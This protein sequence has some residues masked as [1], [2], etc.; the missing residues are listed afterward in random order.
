MAAMCDPDKCTGCGLCASMCR[1]QAITMVCKRHGHLYPQIYKEKCTNCGLCKQICPANSNIRKVIPQHA[2]AAWSKDYKEYTTST[3]GGASAELAKFFIARGGVVYG[4]TIKEG[5]KAEHIRVENAK[6]L[7]LIK[8]SK[9]VQSNMVNAIPLIREDVRRGKD[10]LFLGT[11]CQVGALRRLI[12]ETNPHL[13]LVDLICHGVPSQK[14]LYNHISKI[15]I[16]NSLTRICFRNGKDLEMSIYSGNKLVYCSDAYNQ[17]Y[18]DSYYAAFVE[19]FSF[20]SSCYSCPYA[21]S[22][23]C[24]DLTIGDFWGLK[25]EEKSIPEHPHGCSLILS[26]TEKGQRLIN[27]ISNNMNMFE[28][29]LEEAIAGNSQ[30]RGPSRLT[31]RKRI[32]R[33]LR[34]YNSPTYIYLLSHLDIIIKKRIYKFLKTPK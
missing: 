13:F 26:M 28:R 33:G 30:L 7:P 8:G 2:F 21:E 29:P 1:S 9:Y 4:C 17:P 6:D 25:D 5:V 32:Y 19:G 12:P 3:S 15:V 22:K 11:P 10:V 16:P 14:M 24:G 20:R 31:L 18:R 34:L 23:R 27:G